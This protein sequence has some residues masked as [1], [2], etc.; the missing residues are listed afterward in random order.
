MTNIIET[1][2]DVFALASNATEFVNTCLK[3]NKRKNKNKDSAKLA[4]SGDCAKLASSGDLAQLASSGRSA[5][6]SAIGYKSIAKAKKGDG[7]NYVV[8]VLAL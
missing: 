7:N 2:A 6:I 1:L 4:S 3:E 8:L 5:V